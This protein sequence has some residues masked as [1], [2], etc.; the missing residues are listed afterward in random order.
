MLSKPV[1]TPVIDQVKINRNMLD[2]FK[3]I[4]RPK[5]VPISIDEPLYPEEVEEYH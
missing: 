4:E 2:F 5:K 3:K 1:N